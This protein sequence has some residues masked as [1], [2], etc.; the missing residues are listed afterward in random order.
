MLGG[1]LNRSSRLFLFI[2][3]LVTSEAEKE[4]E[5]EKKKK[6]KNAFF[7]TDVDEWNVSPS[8]FG[9]YTHSRQR[10]YWSK[11]QVGTTLHHSPD[12]TVAT[13]RRLERENNRFT[14]MHIITGSWELTYS[15]MGSSLLF[16][17]LHFFDDDRVHRVVSSS[18]PITREVKGDDGRPDVVFHLDLGFLAPLPFFFYCI[19]TAF[20]TTR[21][22]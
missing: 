17:T 11:V 5:R 18:S 19:W 2:R 7:L 4:R 12:P 10:H 6:E 20:D 3:L 16:S 22:N 8:F 1:V 13:H 9:G 14:T 15:L 21:S